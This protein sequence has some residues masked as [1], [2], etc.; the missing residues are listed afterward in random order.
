MAGELP[1]Y[2]A[3]L[4]LSPCCCCGREGGSVHHPTQFRFKHPEQMGVRAHDS[5]ALPMRHGCHM[6]LHAL[7]GRFKG[8]S[9]EE[10]QGWEQ[11]QLGALALLGDEF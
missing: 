6:D 5:F 9:R 2:T 4:R 1:A 7:A 11:Q 3:R 10:L 8:W